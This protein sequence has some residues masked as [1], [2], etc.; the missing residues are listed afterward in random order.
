M[1]KEIVAYTMR[2]EIATEISSLSPMIV[3]T[4]IHHE[5]YSTTET[6][7]TGE[8]EISDPHSTKLICPVHVS[9][10]YVT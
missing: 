1:L 10:L 5:P 4:D 2:S 8:S 9:H 6:E 7:N 3:P